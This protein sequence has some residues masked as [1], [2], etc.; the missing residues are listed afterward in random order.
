MKITDKWVDIE[1]LDDFNKE[2]SERR[3]FESKRQEEKR[4]EREEK[5]QNVVPKNGYIVLIHLYP[6]GNYKFTYTTGLLLE[7]KIQN[8]KEQYNMVDIVH[9]IE[10]YDTMNFFHQFIRKQFSNRLVTGSSNEYQLTEDDI[11]YIKDEIFPSNAMDWMEG[12]KVKTEN[13][14]S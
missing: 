6:S 11:Q 2:I 10:T 1:S 14:E 7:Q 5:K 3:D 8:I 12:S 4:R 13:V 9:S